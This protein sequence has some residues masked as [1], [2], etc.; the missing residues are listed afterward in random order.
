MMKVINLLIL[1]TLAAPV[2][3][4]EISPAQE[5]TAPASVAEPQQLQ[6][7]FSRA[8]L[9]PAW[10]R[11]TPRQ[12]ISDLHAG[13]AE[14]EQRLLAIAELPPEKRNFDNTF[15]AYVRSSENLN[16]VLVYLNHLH[17]AGAAQDLLPVLSRAFS[18]YALFRQNLSVMPRVL[19]VLRES[20]QSEWAK[21]LPESHQIVIKRVLLELKHSGVHLSPEQKA[22]KTAIE[23]ELQFLCFSFSH[24]L[25]EKNRELLITHSDALDGVPESLVQQAAEAARQRGFSTPDKPAWLLNLASEDASAVLRYCNVSETRERV[26]FALNSA[27]TSLSVDNEPIIY[28]IM[29]LRHELATLLG[30]RHYADMKAA[31]RMLDSGEKAL[32]LVDELLNRSKPAWDARVAKKLQ[33]FS[34]ITGEKITRLHP[35]DESYLLAHG[36]GKPQSPAELPFRAEPLM[37][38]LETQGVINRMLS[39]WSSLLGVT[40]TELPTVCP[41]AG[42]TPPPGHVE[43]WAEGIRCFAVHDTQSGKH[44][45]SFYLDIY[46]RPGKPGTLNYCYPLRLG[47]S[48]EPQLVVMELNFPAP[49]SGRPELLTVQQLR[50]LF[51]EFGHLMH[52]CLCEPELRTLASTCIEPDFC[53]FPSML[54]ENWV[55]EPE[56]FSAVARHH[57]SGAPVPSELLQ[58]LAAFRNTPSID[59]HINMLR[60]AKLDLE[61]H[62]HF[63]EK[64]KNRPLDTVCAEMLRPWLFPGAESAPSPFRTLTHCISAGYDAGFY[65]YKWCE[66]MA[67]DAFSRFRE[68]GI[69]NPAAGE[70]YR[71]AV[72]TPGA[73]RPAVQ[74][75]RD[76]MGRAPDSAPLFNRYGIQPPACNSAEK[77]SE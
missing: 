19:A 55:W 68:T 13:M 58:Q 32:A 44:L 50:M 30:Y 23:Q 8:A 28:R 11:M 25:T 42:D 61:L 35:W 36:I 37:P 2:L 69:L 76:F 60:I 3:R 64:F 40:Y 52:M 24:N 56:V 6:H 38:Y 46:A 7:P 48:G 12:A 15:C 41:A 65:A 53:E 51:H 33:R 4:G 77:V 21:E 43:T 72:L 31:A 1:T 17:N 34:E 62:M 39:L 27:G 70:A 54:L 5:Q 71:R 22:R 20:A 10:S 59:E 74:L 66:L 45:G 18:E 73:S 63:H 67:A 49:V 9:Y 75:F 29:E 47:D 16:Q 14:T 26:W 57:S